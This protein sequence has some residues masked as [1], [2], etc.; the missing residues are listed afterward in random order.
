[1]VDEPLLPTE[2]VLTIHG[3]CVPSARTFT[4]QTCTTVVTRQEFDQLMRIVAP[5]AQTAPGTRRTVAQM[6]AELLAFDMAARNS[7]LE[8]SPESQ[9]T[10][11]LVRLRTIADLYR[12]N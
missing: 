12:R 9:E 4:N 10:L 2:P 11:R 6:Y 1:M 5:G 8:K 7:G 3:P